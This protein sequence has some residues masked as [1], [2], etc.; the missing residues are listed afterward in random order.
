MALVNARSRTI[1]IAVIERLNTG[2]DPFASDFLSEH[3]ITLDECYDMADRLAL[4]ASLLLALSSWA[5]G[6]QPERQMAAMLLAQSIRETEDETSTST[7]R[8]H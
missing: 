7:D 2:G 5:R 8:G 3:S 4:G 1:L 6:T